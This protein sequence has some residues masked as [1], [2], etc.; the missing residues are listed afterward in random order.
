MATFFLLRRWRS[1]N[2]S[3]TPTFCCLSPVFLLRDD[4]NKKT[5]VEAS[6]F[7]CRF[8]AAVHA[9]AYLS[10]ISCCF[11]LC[12]FCCMTSTYL[13]ASLL[14][15]KIKL[16]FA[17]RL[18]ALVDFAPFNALKPP[19]T[20]LIV[21]AGVATVFFGFKISIYCVSDRNCNFWAR[22]GFWFT[23]QSIYHRILL[24]SSNNVSVRFRFQP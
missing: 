5:V 1:P 8:S 12:C 7:V 14:L 23:R 22:F 6:I 13:A 16:I 17:R 19:H 10:V 9:A 24:R 20:G 21:F 11:A 4:Q 3:H 18:L 15:S 2:L